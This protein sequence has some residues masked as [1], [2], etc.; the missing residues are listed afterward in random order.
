MLTNVNLNKL[1]VWVLASFA[2]GVNLSV[3]GRLKA[4]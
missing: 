4:V 2:Q 3:C 1:S